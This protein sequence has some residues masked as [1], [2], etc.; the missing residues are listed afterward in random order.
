MKIIITGSNGL[1]GQKISSLLAQETDYTVLQTSIERQNFNPL[2]GFD[3]AQLDITKKSDVKSLVHS[4]K[5]DV[6]LN[7]AGFTNV[8]DAENLREQAWR[9]NVDGTKNL[10][11]ASRSNSSKIIH[12]SSDYVFNGKSGPYSETDVPE[13]VNYY[14]KT[15]LA[16]ENALLVS[17]INCAI[18]RTTQVYGIG[19]YVKPNFALWIISS[20]QKNQVIKVVDDQFGNPTFSDDV[21]YSVLK[22]IRGNRTGLFHIAGSETINRYKFAVEI[23][24]IFE[25]NKKLIKPV[26][27]ADLSQTAF[28]PM[29]AGLTTFR[30]NSEMGIKFLNPEEGLQVL[31]RQIE[32]EGQYNIIKKFEDSKNA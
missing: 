1:L 2:R 16:A 14:G 26:K 18:I 11:I 29:K 5:P 13:P 12:I 27:T 25:L 3:Y 24:Q 22:V 28:R 20:L 21:A 23:A 4:F 10:I 7:T 9:L 17:R 19:A 15:K 32:L 31:K 30:A 6:I 8:D